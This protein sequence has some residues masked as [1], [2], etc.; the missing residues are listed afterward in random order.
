MGIPI[1][2]NVLPQHGLNVAPAMQDCNGIPVPVGRP[3]SSVTPSL[4][5]QPIS[6]ATSVSASQ[7]SAS[8]A[9]QPSIVV[10]AA[11]AVS[12]A[13]PTPAVLPAS[14]TADPVGLLKNLL[15]DWYSGWLSYLQ[16]SLGFTDTMIQQTSA[17]FAILS[18]CV[19]GQAGACESAIWQQMSQWVGGAAGGS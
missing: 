17:S 16:T 11:G 7:V 10:A 18:P 8:P 2:Q 3:C 12:S 15:G 5:T 14:S 6:T 19:A 9:V 1:Q 13:A 4:I